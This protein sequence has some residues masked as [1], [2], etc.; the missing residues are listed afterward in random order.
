MNDLMNP[1]GQLKS[2]QSFDKIK[3]SIASPELIRSW[4]FGEIKK[5]ET[6]NY[7]TFKPEK[8]GLFCAR[9]FGPV[10]DYECLCG[11]Y[12][13]M[14]YRGIICEKCGVEVTLSKVRRERMG[15]I[16]LAAP[17]AHIWFLK[18]L[19][20]RIGLLVDM[21]LKDLERVLYFEYFLVTEPGLTSLTKGQLL[22]EEDYDGALD[23]FGD[24]SFEVS[25]GA[26]ELKES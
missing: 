5:P 6:I 10:R 15:H 20:S 11:K 2:A 14:K 3:I 18:S 7:R 13:R 16:D 25:I 24:E 19:P 4:S 9:I 8:D 12:K 1:F 22:T 17:V 26:E 21:T 23:E